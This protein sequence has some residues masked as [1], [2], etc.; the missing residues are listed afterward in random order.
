MC[1]A[2][3]PGDRESTAR[4]LVNEC[5]A[6]VSV[7]LGRLMG[8]CRA[9]F[10]PGAT[11]PGDCVCDREG[12]GVSGTCPSSGLLCACPRVRPQSAY[13]RSHKM[14]P[15][16]T[17]QPG[18]LGPPSLPCRLPCRSGSNPGVPGRPARPRAAH[19]PRAPRD[20]GGRPWRARR[21]RRRLPRAVPGRAAVGALCEP[22][23]ERGGRAGG[24]AR[25]G[26]T[27]SRHALPRLARKRYC[28]G[29]GSRRGQGG[30]LVALVYAQPSAPRVSCQS[31]W[32]FPVPPFVTKSER[33]EKSLGYPVQKWDIPSPKNLGQCQSPPGLQG[34]WDVVEGT[35][36]WRWV[37][38]Y[39]SAWV[40]PGS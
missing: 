7:S 11:T 18:T 32:T 6:W 1:G 3:S 23:C 15:A 33:R 16:P 17:L 4:R 8:S 26:A 10:C 36:I 14:T 40:L 29:L 12:S 31:K 9:D 39:L 35:P 21:R 27:P 19:L 34:K 24:G 37:L 5:E 22:V 25:R 30:P 20:T 38:S 2:A 28:S 13:V